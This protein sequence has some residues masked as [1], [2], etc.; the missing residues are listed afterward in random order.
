[1]LSIKGCAS[2][3]VKAGHEELL[4]CF[5][6][7]I[8]GVNY[9][10][11]SEFINRDLIDYAALQHDQMTRSHLYHANDNAHVEQKK[12]TLY[13]VMLSAQTI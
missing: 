6:F 12:G 8:W 5:H 13:V 10:S 11:G 7:T 4:P 2:G 1:M 3:Y 9:D